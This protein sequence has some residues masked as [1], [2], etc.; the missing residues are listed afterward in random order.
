MHQ[1]FCKS[2]HHLGIHQDIYIHMNQE[3]WY[4]CYWCLDHFYDNYEYLHQQLH[5]DLKSKKWWLNT[6]ESVY[7]T[8]TLINI[9][10]SCWIAWISFETGWT[11]A[12]IRT[13]YIKGFSRR[14]KPLIKLHWVSDHPQTVLWHFWSGPQCAAASKHSFMSTHIFTWKLGSVVNSYPV[15][16]VQS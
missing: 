9:N 5:H 2:F 11:Y 1:F 16:Q 3:C 13:G 6:I 10:A 7:S 8:C 15:R 12:L 14:T 4:N